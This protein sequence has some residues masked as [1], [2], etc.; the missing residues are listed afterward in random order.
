MLQSNGDI[1]GAPGNPAQYEEIKSAGGA[2][3]T[4]S[5][6]EASPTDP[7]PTDQSPTDESFTDESPLPAEEEKNA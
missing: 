2:G 1:P 7:I 5:Q 6:K 4:D 3:P